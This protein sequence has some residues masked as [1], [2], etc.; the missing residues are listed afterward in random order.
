MRPPVSTD[1]HGPSCQ[2]V[3]EIVTD[4]LEDALEPA[5]RLEVEAHLAL[6]PGC[7]AYLDQMRSTIRVLG[8]I[9]TETLSE[10]AQADLVRAFRPFRTS[11]GTSP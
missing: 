8:E 9:P 4:Y 5:H 10:R 3:V 7:E 2:Q 11:P 6:C 1:T